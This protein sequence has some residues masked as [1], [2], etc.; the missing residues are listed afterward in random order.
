MRL[1][2]KCS[3]ALHCLI[4]IA[5]YEEKVKVTSELLAK[6]TGCNS[7]AIR[8]ILNALQKANIISVVR[9]VGG[10]HLQCIPS[11]LTLW[12]V[13]HALEP[14]GLEH[15]IGLHPNP[16]DHCPVGSRIESVLKEPYRKIGQAVK[17]QMENITLQQLLDHYNAI[18]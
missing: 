5:Q 15:F 6:S 11:E 14:E 4:F 1:N 17:Q 13:Y 18:S 8:S 9:G 3:I 12:E 7:A 16:S 2:T 10:A